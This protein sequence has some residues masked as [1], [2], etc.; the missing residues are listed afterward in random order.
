MHQIR[1]SSTLSPFLHRRRINRPDHGVS[2]AGW[3][4]GRPH[5]P[6]KH[7]FY[8]SPTCREA[9][10]YSILYNTMDSG[11]G[12]MNQL[13]KLDICNN[14]TQKPTHCLTQSGR[15]V[16][17]DDSASNNRRNEPNQTNKLQMKTEQT[18]TKHTKTKQTNGQMGTKIERMDRK[19]KN[20]RQTDRQ[21][22]N[23]Q[24]KRHP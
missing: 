8:I 2:P 15:Q 13:A 23:G 19:Q 21:T 7:F 18:N 9:H 6:F 4:G 12:Q 17:G 14:I 1:R 20:G 5:T 11:N 16:P 24:I 3:G 22:K 10:S